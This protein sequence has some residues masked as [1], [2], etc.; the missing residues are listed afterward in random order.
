MRVKTLEVIHELLESN[1][2]RMK[3][4][5]EYAKKELRQQE[6][7]VGRGE[8]PVEILEEY[9]KEAEKATKRSWDAADALEDFLAHSWS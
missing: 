7:R 6:E 8:R 1:A 2:L 4:L 3:S 9:R 5:S